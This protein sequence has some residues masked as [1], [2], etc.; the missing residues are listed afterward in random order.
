MNTTQAMQ[1]MQHEIEKWDLHEEGW[2]A[3]FHKRKRSL[4]TC[5]YRKKQ[6]LLSVHF[7]EL[8]ESEIIDTV[9]HEVAHALAGPE[10]GHGPVWKEWARKVGAKPER[11]A[12]PSKRPKGKYLLNCPNCGVI[13]EKHRVNKRFRE[14]IDQELYR[15]V[16][17]Q[18][19]HLFLTDAK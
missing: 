15:C 19:N 17:C 9:K 16:K 8:T 11:C 6:I 13:E 4:G 2:T 10:A 5:N 3:G 1:L 12:D 14:M 7:L 18:S